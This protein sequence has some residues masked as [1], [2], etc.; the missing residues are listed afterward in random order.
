MT[1]FNIINILLMIAIVICGIFTAT[2]KDKYKAITSVVI[3][4]L[5]LI[6]KLLLLNA[7]GVAFAEVLGGGI[8]VLLLFLSL[9]RA[10]GGI[11]K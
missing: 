8:Y 1:G 5:F 4:S 3:M 2:T 6:L 7:P 9:N 10:K 11:S